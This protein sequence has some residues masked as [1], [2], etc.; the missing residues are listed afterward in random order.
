MI[1]SGSLGNWFDGHERHAELLDPP[2]EVVKHA[3]AVTYFEIVLPLIGVLPPF[4]EY[5]VDE[6]GDFLGGDGGGLGFVHA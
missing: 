1:F 4:G 3:L 2:G 6:A 5:G